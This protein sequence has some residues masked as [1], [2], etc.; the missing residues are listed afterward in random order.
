MA[1]LLDVATGLYKLVIVLVPA[2]TPPELPARDYNHQA[3]IVEANGRQHIVAT[4]IVQLRAT[5]T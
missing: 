2:D 4:G 3:K 1:I 5:M